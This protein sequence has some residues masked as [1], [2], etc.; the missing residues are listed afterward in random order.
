[1]NNAVGIG[2]LDK[3]LSELS[4]EERDRLA[5]ENEELRADNAFL[6]EAIDAAIADREHFEAEADSL[7]ERIAEIERE[8]APRKEDEKPT[9]HCVG[10]Q[11]FDGHNMSLGSKG[12][13]HRFPEPRGIY[14]PEAHW[15]GEFKPKLEFNIRDVMERE[16]TP[17]VPEISISEY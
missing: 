17:Q 7:R 8:V 9:E 15:C 14:N 1:M 4:Q 3:M 13:C 12:T 2:D 11:L 6:N 16:N 5:K 10:C